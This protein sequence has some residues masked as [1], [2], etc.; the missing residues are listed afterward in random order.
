MAKKL[1]TPEAWGRGSGHPGPPR[2]PDREHKVPE[3]LGK[4]GCQQIA[5]VVDSALTDSSN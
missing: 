5:Q 4:I 2:N 3:E 1:F